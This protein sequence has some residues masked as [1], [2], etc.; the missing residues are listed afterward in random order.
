[1]FS[2]EIGLYEAHSAGSFP[3]LA[4]SII[5]ASFRDGGSEAS[6]RDSDRMVVSCGERSAENLLKNL[7]GNPSGPGDFPDC[8]DD[9]ARVISV[10]VRGASNFSTKFG[11][12]VGTGRGS[13]K[14]LND[15]S[16]PS[17]WEEYSLE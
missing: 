2:S 12:I 15:I 16:S 4:M 10:C 1:M 8:I 6:R 5:H 7:A 13:R 14:A 9:M 11:G 3:L 17:N